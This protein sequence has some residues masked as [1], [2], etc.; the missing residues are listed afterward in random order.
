MSLSHAGEFLA[1]AVCNRPIGIDIE[2]LGRPEA[3]AALA[4]RI[5]TAAELRILERVPRARRRDELLRLWARKEA[6][7]KALG[8][9][10]RVVFAELEAGSRSGRVSSPDAGTYWIRD[11]IDDSNGYVMA[12]AGA[13]ALWRLRRWRNRDFARPMAA[14][15]ETLA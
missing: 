15:F 13:G 4:A 11:R 12:V 14:S 5:C 10:L 8:R 1:C 3:D 7:A 6:T 2:Q 9:G